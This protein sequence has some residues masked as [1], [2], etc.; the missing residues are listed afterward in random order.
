M[1]LEGEAM[2]LTFRMRR[3]DGTFFDCYATKR[4]AVGGWSVVPVEG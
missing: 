3:P 2:T 4:E 1:H